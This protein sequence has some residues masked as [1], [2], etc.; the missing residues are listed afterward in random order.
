MIVRPLASVCLFP[1]TKERFEWL[2][3]TLQITHHMWSDR[4]TAFEGKHFT[5][6]EPLCR[7]QPVSNPHPPIMIGGMGEKKT[8]RF[9]GT[10]RRCLQPV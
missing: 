7:P 9:C 8:L 2:E 1:S 5:L 10:V 3:E 6:K 4:Q